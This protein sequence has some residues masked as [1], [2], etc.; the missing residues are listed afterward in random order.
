M[1]KGF[2]ALYLV[3]ALLIL[4]AL[5]GAY[6]FGRSSI[7]QPIPQPQVSTTPV[8]TPQPVWDE[9]TGW[10]TYTSKYGYSIKYPRNWQVI[11]S[12]WSDDYFTYSVLPDDEVIM[13]Y[14]KPNQPQHAGFPDGITLSLKKPQDNMQNLSARQ[15]AE[16]IYPPGDTASP[17]QASVEDIMVQGIKA[18][19]VNTA[20]D[21]KITIVFIPYQAKMYQ[22]SN[23]SVSSSDE[24]E[25]IFN[26]ILST[27]R[28]LDR[29]NSTERQFCGGFAGKECP[30]GY[31]CKLDGNYPDAGGK[32]VSSTL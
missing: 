24:Y 18:S 12:S 11:T 15:W 16:K 8:L 27:F 17:Y 22:L 7:K 28:F 32:C 10:E 14:T 3:I 21:G 29:E 25:I 20:F 2:T 19:K 6:Y 30:E 26:Q 9:S 5:G 1:Q 4:A 23:I 31:T 13:R